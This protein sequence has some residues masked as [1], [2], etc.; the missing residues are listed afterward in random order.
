MDLIDHISPPNE[1]GLATFSESLN[2]LVPPTT[3]RT[4]IRDQ[5]E[6]MFPPSG[7]QLPLKNRR[8]ALWDA[9]RDSVK[10]LD[11][12]QI[13]DVIFV[14]TDGMDNRSKAD[15][16]EAADSLLAEGIRLFTLQ[17][18]DQHQFYPFRHIN[19]DAYVA[20]SK[21]AVQTGGLPVVPQP[22]SADP[23]VKGRMPPWLR[24]DLDLQYR[25]ILYFFRFDV[26]LSQPLD[27]QREWKISVVT[28]DK[29]VKR[30]FE[31]NYQKLLLPCSKT[32]D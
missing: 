15:A 24:H 26:T 10:L 23:P 22:G 12:H 31:L 13:G 8:T 11:P 5:I 3:D 18:M 32:F 25:Q 17:V 7:I 14:I 9:L 16:S 4:K 20:L 19:D 2:M 21:V 6:S 28:P 30:N 27:K 29:A 1:I